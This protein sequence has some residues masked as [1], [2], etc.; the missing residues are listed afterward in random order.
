MISEVLS[1]SNPSL[2]AANSLGK[3]LRSGVAIGGFGAVVVLLGGWWLTLGVGVIVHLGL[4]EF[5]RMAQFKGIRPATKTTLVACQL[6]LITTQWAAVQSGWPEALSG[7]VLP[8]AGAAI[9][10]WLLPQPVTGSIADI[11]A[12]IF[13]LFYLGFLS[14]LVALRNLTSG[15]GSRNGLAMARSGHY[16]V[17]LSDDRGQRHRLMGIR[18]TLGQDSLISDFTL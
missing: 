9:C 1:S 4:L 12:S 14:P 16:F 11:A 3:R 2:R 6:L 17:G 13:G 7:A 8:L 5:F 15:P 18:S 10:A